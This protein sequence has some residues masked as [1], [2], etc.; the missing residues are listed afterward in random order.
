VE[1][2]RSASSCPLCVISCGDLSRQWLSERD[3]GSV[4]RADVRVSWWVALTRCCLINL[5]VDSLEQKLHGE[6]AEL[7]DDCV[8]VDAWEE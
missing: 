7:E 1:K 2:L 4:R 6:P 3:V 5:G 8:C